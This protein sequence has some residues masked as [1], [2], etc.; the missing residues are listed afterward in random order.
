Q[1]LKLIN[2]IS[3]KSE[4][5]A[6]AIISP[7]SS[8][9]GVVTQERGLRTVSAPFYLGPAQALDAAFGQL[10]ITVYYDNSQKC[11]RC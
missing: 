11:I 7:P 5:G 10:L 1:Y 3:N 4:K 2:N 9:F 8:R 6:E